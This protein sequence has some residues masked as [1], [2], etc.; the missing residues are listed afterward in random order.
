[1][2]LCLGLGLSGRGKYTT[3]LSQGWLS[4]I[5]KYAL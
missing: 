1:M 5:M 3:P 2:E 4:N